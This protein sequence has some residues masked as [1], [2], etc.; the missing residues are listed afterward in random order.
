MRHRVRQNRMAGPDNVRAGATRVDRHASF[1][2]FGLILALLIA[3]SITGGFS[4]L[5]GPLPDAIGADEFAGKRYRGQ[6]MPSPHADLATIAR[7]CG[8][9]VGFS[10]FL[11]A[12]A[13]YVTAADVPEFLASY[14]LS[15]DELRAR[16]WEGDCND[17]AHA[18][19]EV[20]ARQGFAMGFVSLW[21]RRW[22]ELFSQDWHQVAVL[23]LRAGESYV[24]FDNGSARY[25]RGTLD[26]YARSIDKS[27][28]PIGGQLHWRPTRPNPLAR[29]VDHARLNEPL[30]ECG[31]PLEGVGPSAPVL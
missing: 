12:H 1:A 18:V 9:P 8:N 5:A 16:N 20:G 30:P 17:L 21:P 10:R 19:C 27:I 4:E 13:R 22:S 23:C 7:V 6:G 25:W 31:R 14:R 2:S 24:I 3:T 11:E 28:I 15:T 29:L 26:D